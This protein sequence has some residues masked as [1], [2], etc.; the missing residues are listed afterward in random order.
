ME[1]GLGTYCE[2]MRIVCLMQ[3]TVWTQQADG[4]ELAVKQQ[5][6][7]VIVANLTLWTHVQMTLSLA[8]FPGIDNMCITGSKLMRERLGVYAMTSLKDKIL[9]GGK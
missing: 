8:V 4:Q 7:R 1:A 6:R 5:T 3:R 9:Q 2:G